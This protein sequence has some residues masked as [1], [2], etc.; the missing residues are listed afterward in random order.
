MLG[1]LE[2]LNDEGSPVG[3][4]GSLSR[5]VVGRLLLA[6]GQPV[7]RDTIID[8]LWWE[9]EVK[10]PVN[11]LQVQVAKLRAV[12]AA[13]GAD[14]RIETRQGG[15]Q[16]VLLPQDQFDVSAF[17]DLVQQGREHLRNGAYGQADQNLRAGV[18]LWR[19]RALDDLV[20]RPFDIE[21]TRLEEHRLSAIEDAA[22]A[23]L[24]LGRA[25]EL[26]PELSALLS[27]TPL[28]ERVRAQLMLAL[29]RCGRHAEALEVF[30]KGRKLLSSELGVDP[31]PDLRSLHSAILRHDQS[32]KRENGDPF[33]LSPKQAEHRRPSRGKGNLVRPLGPFV[34]RRDVLAALCEQVAGERLVSVVG[35]GGVGKTRLTL[36]ACTGLAPTHDGVWWVDLTAVGDSGVL[37]AVASTLGLS[38]SSAKPDQQPHDYMYRAAS[39]LGGR[40]TILALDNCEHVLDAAAPLVADLLSRCPQL[41]V[42]ATS[43][44]P[45]TV[46]GEVLFPLSPMS[47]EESADLFSI[48]AMMINP[49]FS[50]DEASMKEIRALCRRL[51]GL[52]LAVE[53][54]AA[55]ARLLPLREITLRLDDRFALLTRG[56]RTAP[57]RHQTL[58]AVLDWSYTLLDVSE[59]LVLTE[60]ALHVGGCSLDQAER[61]GLIQP[62]G[63]GTDLMHLLTQLVDKSL[64]SPVTAV[65][66]VRLQMLET[67]REYALARLY[68][69]GRGPEAE[70]RFTAWAM[71]LTSDGAT[72]LSS[73]DQTTWVT[74]LTEESANIR[75][76]SDLLIRQG[77]T[78]ES[79][80]LEAHLG[81]YWFVSGREEEGI[82]RL[83][84]S[85]KAYEDTRSGRSGQPTPD[86]EWAF[87]F[88]FAWLAWLSHIA[89]KHADASSYGLRYQAAWRHA[90]HPDLAILGPCYDT[91][92]AMLNSESGVAEL[93]AKAEA[94]IS[95]TQFHWN[96]AVLQTNWST[97]CLQQGDVE[98]ARNHGLAALE[99]SHAADD[100]FAAAFSVKLC[101]DAD[102]SAGRRDQ[103][104]TQWCEAAQILRSIGSRTRLAYA[105]LRLTCL[106]IAEGSV[107][108]AEER[109]SEVEQLAAAL[110]ADDIK[111][112]ADNLRGVLAAFHNRFAEAEGIFRAV[113]DSPSAPPN[114]KAVAGLGL[115]LHTTGHSAGN[116]GAENSGTEVSKRWLRLAADTHRL[117]L[118]PLARDAVG[119]LVTDLEAGH[120]DGTA[121]SHRLHE[122]MSGTPSVLAAFY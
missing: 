40:R 77:S 117:L 6:G 24:E 104:R 56:E 9:R 81:Y 80:V 108:T 103:A 22:A 51:D 93:F 63:D 75:A 79:L 28:R 25:E 11:A 82:E 34:G 29:Y 55:Y 73:K 42:V 32:L 100:A 66:G 102:E 50:T 105:L 14:G 58:R 41:T 115:A 10:D 83:K 61:A 44:E 30:D 109:L 120:E 65:S 69:E 64:L 49:S 2:V 8:E 112:A 116:S 62:G 20:G 90:K 68:E 54:A 86:E 59:Q 26:V 1:R 45:L 16:L 89:G 19:G 47:P 43:R 60:L 27:E 70:D 97:Y 122:R 94:G 95:G 72:G 39:F 74:T 13:N 31:S 23:C 18:S 35:P 106:D 38:D 21:R 110:S 87:F 76:A 5:S 107:S 88:T 46:P 17:E 48:R 57:A 15:Y 3:L 33:Q 99:A 98:G 36:E 91:L 111:S 53:L 67:V 85:L 96:R 52:P 37:A 114:R 78:V 7:Q 71:R 119:L 101:G 121:G 118:E 113:W 84:R 12:F 4:P 92:Y